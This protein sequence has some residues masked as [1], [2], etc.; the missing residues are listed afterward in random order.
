MTVVG[1]EPTVIKGVKRMGTKEDNKNRPILAQCTTTEERNRIVELARGSTSEQLNGIRLRKDMHPSVRAE[2]RRL[3]QVKEN[4][5]KRAENAGR[6][7]TIDIRKRQV[8]RGDQ[9]IDSLCNQL[10]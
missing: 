5:E 2:W 4:E 9:V 7:I 1:T 3:F 6:R 10:F 8:L